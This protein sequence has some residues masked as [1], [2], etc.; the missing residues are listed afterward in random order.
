MPGNATNVKKFDTID[1]ALTAPRRVT[2]TAPKMSESW[3]R[4]C[5]PDV[6]RSMSYIDHSQGGASLCA[7]VERCSGSDPKVGGDKFLLHP[8]RI[9]LHSSRY[10]IDHPA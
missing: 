3:S 9:P 4:G 8:R 7:R 2:A 1:H 6:K 5:A 10:G